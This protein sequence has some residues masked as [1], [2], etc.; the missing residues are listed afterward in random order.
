MEKGRQMNF[1]WLWIGFEERV[2]ENQAA[3]EFVNT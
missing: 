1:D 3:N 2:A